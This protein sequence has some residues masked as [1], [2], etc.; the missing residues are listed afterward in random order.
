[1]TKIYSS[2][3]DWAEDI[4]EQACEEAGIVLINSEDRD[5]CI[6]VAVRSIRQ[7]AQAFRSALK[8]SGVDTDALGIFCIDEPEDLQN[9]PTPKGTN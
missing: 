7:A 2:F 8:T 6:G 1:V 3:E 5:I 4:V 9:Q